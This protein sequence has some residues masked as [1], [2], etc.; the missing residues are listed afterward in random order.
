[1]ASMLMLPGTMEN[2]GLERV[3]ASP[4]NRVSVVS[5]YFEG[6][7]RVSIISNPVVTSQVG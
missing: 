1:M 5:L 2:T 6:S 7:K 4:W 3:S